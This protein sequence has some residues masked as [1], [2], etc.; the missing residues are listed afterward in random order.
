MAKVYGK[1]WETIDPVGEGGQAVAFLVR[2]LQDPDGEDRWVLKRLKN[3]NRLG[4]FETEI[5]ALQQVKSAQI[6]RVEDHSLADP[7]YLVY[8]YIGPSL[9]QVVDKLS[10]DQAWSLFEDVVQAVMDAHWQ[11]IAHRDIKPQN[12]LVDEDPER[13]RAY[14]IDFGICQIENGQVHTLTDEAL[15][16]RAFAAPELDAGALGAP[17]RKSDIY[18]L[19]KLL[20]WMVTRGGFFAREDFERRLDAVPNDRGVERSYVRYFLSRTVVPASDERI[21]VLSLR[22]DL[23]TAGRLIRLGANMVGAKDQ[24]CPICR[25]GTL[26]RRTGSDPKDVG[27][28]PRGISEE[29]FRLLH[30]NYCGYLQAHDIRNTTASDRWE[31]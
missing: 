18:S 11:D 3:T 2:D 15:G 7:A 17:G 6:P 25:L 22:R 9:D 27:F 13:R 31:I 4:R 8:P 19:G 23:E 14:L 28:N 29:D 30:C 5:E 20:Y 12:I 21:D 26:R 10:F 24:T 1:R 16:S